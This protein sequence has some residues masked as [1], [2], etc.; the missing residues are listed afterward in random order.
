MPKCST[1]PWY[2]SPL[3]SWVERLAG[4]ADDDGDR[5]TR[6][7]GQFGTR[8]FNSYEELLVSDVDAVVVC[9]ENV[10]HRPMVELAASHGKSVLCEKPLA[11]SVEEGDEMVTVARQADRLLAVNLIMRY[12]PLLQAAKR[13]LDEEL[14]GRPIDM[15]GSQAEMI[16]KRRIV[17]DLPWIEPSMRPLLQAMLQPLPENRPASM[18][19]VAAWEPAAP[20]APTI[21]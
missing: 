17:P 13:I 12:N 19:E 3:Q 16:E 1:R 15:A 14:L 20:R 10:R 18:A 11:I 4:I 7:A 21:S 2:G 9:S 5:A 6:M 8:K